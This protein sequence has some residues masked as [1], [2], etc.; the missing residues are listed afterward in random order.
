[1]R[2][3]RVRQRGRSIPVLDPAA[4]RRP[5]R[6][7]HNAARTEAVSR[8]ALPGRRVFRPLPSP[9]ARATAKKRLRIVLVSQYFPPEIG[10]TQ[11]RMQSFA[12]YLADR[13]HRVT[14]ICEFPNHPQGVVPESYR[15]RL[16]EDD[17]SNALPDPSRLGKDRS[18]EDAAQPDGVLPLVHG[19]RDRGRAA[20]RSG[21]RRARDDPPL[22]TGLAGLAIARMNAAP[23]VLDV[24]DL[25]P[26]AAT[27]LRQISSGWETTAAEE[28]ERRLYQLGGS[29]RGGDPAVLR[30]HRCAANDGPP[31]RADSERHARAVL[32]PEPIGLSDRLGVPPER[33]LV[34]FA[35]TLGIAQ[36]LPSVL[37]A[38]G[39][40][41]DIADFAFI[42]DGPMKEATVGGG[43]APAAARMSTFSRRWRSSC[44]PPILAASDAML[45]PLSAHPT[46]EQFVPSKLIDFMASGRPVLLAA[47][48]ESARILGLAGAGLVLPPEN[49]GAL[50]DGVRWL[51]GHPEEAA[52]M[53]KGRVF[54]RRRSARS[55]PSGS[56]RRCS[57]SPAVRGTAAA[58]D[59]LRDHPEAVHR[60]RGHDPAQRDRLL[61]PGGA[62]RQRAAD[63]R[64]AGDGRGGGLAWRPAAC[65]GRANRSGDATPRQRVRSR[66]RARRGA[67]ALLRERRILL[68]PSL[69]FAAEARY[70]GASGSS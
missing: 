67:P 10:A 19:P 30:P 48:G 24:R 31:G 47:A 59:R 26:A 64:R 37:E 32:R 23:L 6:A 25:W 61:A 39:L 3:R 42:G 35:G 62:R 4:R 60:R 16:L 2:V 68:P 66:R 41:A 7:V 40:V 17:R 29:R 55:R 9:D 56:S 36:A 20:R 5:R 21:R 18:S 38:A 1:M 8:A 53:G 57:T 52:A 13:G 28:L 22:F 63:R 58:R 50:A 65:P 54:A 34:T 49:P 43:S 51:H 12:E 11:L 33:F 44:I 45:V 14:V 27:S 70:A 69:A 15:G 46:F